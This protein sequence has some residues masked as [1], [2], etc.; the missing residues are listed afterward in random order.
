MPP[1]TAPLATE[2]CQPRR[3][4][5]HRIAPETA[6]ELL[7]ELPGWTIID[8]ALCH[9]F[10][11]ADFRT[12]MLFANTVACLAE[13]ENHHPDLEIGY[14]RVRVRYSTHD[15]GGL[16]RNDFICAAKI[17]ALPAL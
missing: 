8:E 16:S 11:F 4:A 6:R 12:A 3:G 10:R 5:E 13:S 14:G 1:L 7:A 17:Q 15:V 2:R 9:E